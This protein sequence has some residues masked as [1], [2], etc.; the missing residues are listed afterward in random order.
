MVAGVSAPAF[1]GSAGVNNTY[2]TSWSVYSTRSSGHSEN[3][4]NGTSD[5]SRRTKKA[6]T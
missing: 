2:T 4:D 6:T 5:S 3:H 1:A